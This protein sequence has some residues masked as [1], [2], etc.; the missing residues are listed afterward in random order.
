[1]HL[2][3]FFSKVNEEKTSLQTTIEWHTQLT[4]LLEKQIIQTHVTSFLDLYREYSEEQLGLKVGKTK[5]AWLTEMIKGELEDVK[6]GKVFLAT[7]SIEN[8]VAGFITCLPVTQRYDRASSSQIV[9]RWRQIQPTKVKSCQESIRQ[10]VYMSLLAVKPIRDPKTGKKIQI[11]LGRQL[12]ERVESRFPD[13]NALTLDT[14]LVNTSGIA[15]YQ[16]L[17]FSLTGQRTFGGSNPV[18]YTGCEKRLMRLV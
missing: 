2:R 11:G 3:S 15:F 8:N 10:D 18:H 17:G 6:A 5:K 7:V 9:Q 14:R 12:V 1:M 16:K 4:P 13:A